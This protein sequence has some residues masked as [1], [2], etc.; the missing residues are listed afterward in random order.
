VINTEKA[1]RWGW[2]ANAALFVILIILVGVW[3]WRD[4]LF[5]PQQAKMAAESRRIEAQTKALGDRL[6]TVGSN[7]PFDQSATALFYN[8]QQIFDFLLNTAED[9]RLQVVRLSLLPTA[10]KLNPVSVVAEFSGGYYGMELFWQQLYGRNV[11]FELTKFEIGPPA[12]P[13]D[14]MHIALEMQVP[15]QVS[16]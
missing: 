5:Q 16:N 11:N 8:R 6:Q 9:S 15:L 10:A 4:A 14:G 7:N 13:D 12:G 2:V 1:L 3:I